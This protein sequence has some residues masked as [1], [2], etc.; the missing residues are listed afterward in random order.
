[1]TEG[2]RSRAEIPPLDVLLEGRGVRRGVTPRLGEEAL[3]LGDAEVPYDRV[4][5]ISRRAGLL[6]VFTDDRALAVKGDRDPLERLAHALEERLGRASGRARLPADL[7]REVVV[8][9]AG[10]AVVGDLE[11]RRASG[12]RVAV[13]TRRGLHLLGGRERMALGWPA[14]E[15][16]TVDAEGAPGPALLLRRGESVLRLLYLFPEEIRTAVRL[17]RSEPGEAPSPGPGGRE[18]SPPER[19]AP[20]SPAGSGAAGP[21]PA[22]AEDAEDAGGGEDADDGVAPGGEGGPSPGEEDPG[23]AAGPSAGEDPSARDA[24]PG[25]E[26]P[27]GEEI[28]AAE[29]EEGSLELFARG[30][31]APPVRSE[32]PE[33]KLSVDVL[34]GAAEEAAGAVPPEPA[35]TAGLPPH[36]LE[37]HL[38]ELGEIAL[39]PVL[40]RKSAAASARSLRKAVE[41]MDAGDLREDARAAV[42]NAANRLA[43]VYG[44]E[45][46]RLVAEKRAPPGVEEEHAL[47][48][49]ELEEIRLRMQ[50]PVD[51]LVPTLRELEEAQAELL[52]RLR[53]FEEGPPDAGEEKV[54]SA[55]EAWT[56]ALRRVDR[57]FERAWEEMV[58]EAAEAWAGRLLPSLAELG[59]MRRRRLPEWATVALLATAT[60][61]LAAAA[62]I[63]L[64][65]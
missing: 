44:T 39:G 57:A 47:E 30:E 29:G 63:L 59:S 41:A 40:L 10:T 18:P 58:D 15:A 37:T 17:A 65:W 3:R 23:G 52:D 22:G 7:T 33:M 60:L 11:G 42:G 35:E 24:R 36:F 13:F 49:E 4:F 8:C 5:W 53:D 32:L 43:E 34:Q 38:V 14:D 51:R 20:P 64:V 54:E 46:D 26:S 55:R 61:L 12:L 2:R 1:M 62:M 50:A 56:N 16:R 28:P 27:A 25:A 48:V 6:M 21:A 19:D 31:V 9:T 45:L